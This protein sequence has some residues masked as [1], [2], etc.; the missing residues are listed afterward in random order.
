MISELCGEW[1]L[2]LSHPPGRLW[3]I[4][5]D[6]ERFNEMSGLPRYELTETPQPD[7]S[8]RRVAQG[9]VAR[10]DIQWEELPVEWVAEQYFFQRRLF[11]NGP[12]RRMDASLRL[13]PEGG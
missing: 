5:S 13:A 11:L 12:L 2:S 9:R 1:R 8:V 10:F 4:L 7:G 6:T 3:P